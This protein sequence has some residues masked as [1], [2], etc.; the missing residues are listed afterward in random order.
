MTTVEAMDEDGGPRD[1][2]VPPIAHAELY[3][4]P[5]GDFRR[6]VAG[7]I[8]ARQGAQRQGL[9]GLLISLAAVKKATRE[10]ENQRVG[11]CLTRRGGG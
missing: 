9:V 1:S 2:P 10:G 7:E 6:E 8:M 5:A 4:I 3:Q 11:E